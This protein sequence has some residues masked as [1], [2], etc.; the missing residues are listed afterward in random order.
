MCSIGAVACFVVGVLGADR[1]WHG[2]G[3]GPGAEGRSRKLHWRSLAESCVARCPG[4]LPLDLANQVMSLVD[5][6]MRD[7]QRSF[8]VR[9]KQGMGHPSG[10]G[11]HKSVARSI[12]T[13]TPISRTPCKCGIVYPQGDTG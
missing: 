9:A 4:L 11:P 1:A 2:V 6:G 8:N 5:V 12:A 3:L 13:Q 10:I 7:V